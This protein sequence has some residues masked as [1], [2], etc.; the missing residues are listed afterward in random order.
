MASRSEV[1]RLAA[2]VVRAFDEQYLR[3]ASTETRINDWQRRKIDELAAALEANASRAHTRATDRKTSRDAAPRDLT[4]SQHRVLR[5]MR[6]GPSTDYELAQKLQGIM[7][8][9]GVRS[10]RAELVRGGLVVDTGRTRVHNKR[11]HT[12]WALAYQAD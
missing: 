2:R 8:P 10:R 6:D 12:V 1:F 3:M 11:K 5:A 4:H 7:S 9:S